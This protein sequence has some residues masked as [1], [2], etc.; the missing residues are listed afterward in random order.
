MSS[1]KQDQSQY[2]WRNKMT[3]TKNYNLPKLGREAEIRLKTAK[4]AALKIGFATIKSKEI[5]P[6][7]KAEE[8]EEFLEHVKKLP[9]ESVNNDELIRQRCVGYASMYAINN[10]LYFLYPEYDPKNGH[11][12][13]NYNLPSDVNPD[14]KNTNGAK[15]RNYMALDPML[16]A[17][18][19][20]HKIIHIGY[21]MS[22]LPEQFENKPMEVEIQ[23]IKYVPRQGEDAVPTP[24]IVHQDQDWAFC[25][26]LITRENV[27]GGKNSFVKKEHV[28]KE[29]HEVPT[30][31]ILQQC[32][33]TELFDGVSVDDQKIGHHV[34]AVSLKHGEHIG[35][36]TILI[37]SYKP[38]V[39]SRP[40]LYAKPS[41]DEKTTENK[42][43][44]PEE[45]EIINNISNASK[46]INLT[47]EAI[48]K[49]AEE[50]EEEEEIKPTY[51]KHN[52][53]F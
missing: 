26:F 44:N 3:Y 15:P 36:R 31:D 40:E 38:L 46:A 20:L 41:L 25:V 49:L 27:E 53:W 22:P 34:D 45:K 13:Q 10:L 12:I 39:P 48:S 9:F 32:T 21:M 4:K 16:V 33:F 18:K 51:L 50:I 2:T 1:Q 28:G 6:E 30:D 37:L 14:F 17:N 35:E 42:N 5:K 47:I 7:F 8:L 19:A 11:F 24:T 43:S 23:F 52:Y 29:L